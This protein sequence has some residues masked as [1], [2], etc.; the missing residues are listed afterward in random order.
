[1]SAIEKFGLTMLIMLT[2]AAVDTHAWYYFVALAISAA[3]FM[4][5]KD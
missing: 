5:A 3:I 2:G 4:L 1:M